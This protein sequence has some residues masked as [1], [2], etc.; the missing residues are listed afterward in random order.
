MSRAVK[1]DLFLYA[2]DTGLVC[3]LNEDFCNICNWFVDNKLSIQ[4][5]EDK[6]R[7]ILFAS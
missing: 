2:D 4:F 1:Y 5:G 6:T 3:Q 7:S